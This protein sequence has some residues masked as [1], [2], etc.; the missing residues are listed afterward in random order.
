M[1]LTFPRGWSR[2][3]TFE[4]LEALNKTAAVRAAN[5]LPPLSIKIVWVKDF[6]FD[7]KD[8]LDEA[9]SQA[10]ATRVDISDTHQRIA[11]DPRLSRSLEGFK[12]SVRR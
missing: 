12:D 2:S 3:R 8:D 6:V 9:L 10:K 4:R 11:E 7:G 1:T 5:A